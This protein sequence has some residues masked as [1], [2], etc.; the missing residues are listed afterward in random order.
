MVGWQELALFLSR[1]LKGLATAN[2]ARVPG[3]VLEVHIYTVALAV[4]GS[5]FRALFVHSRTCNP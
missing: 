2:T 4:I 5:E 1:L 3:K